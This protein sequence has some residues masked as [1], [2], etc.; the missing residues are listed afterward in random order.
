M[1]TPMMEVMKKIRRIHHKNASKDL[2]RP[3][4]FK[5]HRRRL[6]AASLVWSSL[7]LPARAD[8]AS[9]IRI[10]RVEQMPNLPQ[11]FAMRDWKQVARDYDNLVF[12]RRAKGRFLPLIWDDLTHTTCDLDGFGLYNVAGDPRQGPTGNPAFHESVNCL[13]AVVGSGLVGIDKRRQDGYDY[14][15]MCERYFS[16]REKGGIDIFANTP[17]LAPGTGS[18]WY[19]LFPNMLA[20]FLADCYPGHG[21]LDE[22]LRRSADSI[23]EMVDELE[24]SQ[25]YTGYDFVHHQPVYNGRWREGDAL[26]GVG[27]IEYMAWAKFHDAKYLDAARRA[28]NALDSF[29]RSTFYE[30]LLPYGATLAARMNAEVGCNYDV[31]RILNWCFNGDSACRPGWG[32]IVGN[33]GGY[34]VSGL[35]GSITDG[36]GYAFTMNTFEL[37][38]ALA[39]LPRYDA[40]YARA[41]GKLILNTANAAR[42]FYANGL[43][44]ENQTCYDQRDFF[45][46]VIAYEGLRRVGLRPQDAKKVP[47]ACGDPLG[48]R[49]AGH[50]YVS[51]FS[52]YGSSHVGLMAAVID[53]TNDENILQLNCLKTDFFH[54][55]TY[56]TYLYYNP[57]GGAREV[58]ID[59]G[60]QPVDLYDTIRRQFVSRR[61]SGRVSLR[62]APDSAALIVLTPAGGIV[63]HE[64][65]KLL[66][67]GIVVDYHA[68]DVSRS[69]GDNGKAASA[70]KAVLA[71][72]AGQT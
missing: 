7:L 3:D 69:D 22:Y 49:W 43:P 6:L 45:R 18:M 9:Q 29:G 28:M 35:E 2:A 1:D 37:V 42:L 48:G 53:R 61:A 52:L 54:A 46:D 67:D 12:D 25:G 34:D 31:T 66:V 26:A 17:S 64:G 41:V 5:Q 27:W 47:C 38:A 14:V 39:P 55:R 40:R 62:L 32:L 30:V 8:T 33:W 21:R 71:A 24:R 15:R 50:K 10:P 56:P 60:A 4:P 68:G 58:R 70:R 13:A 11:P 20:F 63:T 16:P 51:D 19:F 44:P 36:H 65:D 59:V 23:A 72:R 57:Y